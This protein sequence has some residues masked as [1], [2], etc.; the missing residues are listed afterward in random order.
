MST[1][2]DLAQG[3]TQLAA[4]LRELDE[5]RE[6]RERDLAA[7]IALGT[8][9][10]TAHWREGKYLYLIHPTDSSGHRKR[11]YIGTDPTKIAN[12][13]AAIAREHAAD[14][15]RAQLRTITEKTATAWQYVGW[16]KAALDGLM[17]TTGAN[18]EHAGVTKRA[19]P[20]VTS[21]APQEHASVTSHNLW[22][23]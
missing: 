20:L 13:Q 21:R 15:L 22:E 1:P 8:T 5:Y 6:R 4:E 19:A 14:A 7:L 2:F 16:A 23:H 9:R 12:A 18:Q 17:A 10:A 3:C 11:E